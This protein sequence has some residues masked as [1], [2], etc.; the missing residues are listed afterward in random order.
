[1]PVKVFITVLIILGIGVGT[2][3][4][5]FGILEAVG[6]TRVDVNGVIAGGAAVLATSLSALI[7]HLAGGFRDLD[8]RER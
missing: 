7:A 3:G 8:D 2:G 5:V 1:M 6:A 4:L